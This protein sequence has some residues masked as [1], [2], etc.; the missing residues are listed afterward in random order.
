MVCGVNAYN[1][2]SGSE[3]DARWRRQKE[4]RGQDLSMLHWLGSSLCS[5]LPDEME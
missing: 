3:Q 2:A 5:H 1:G 4:D